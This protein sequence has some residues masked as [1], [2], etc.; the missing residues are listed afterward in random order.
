M[1]WHA[2]RPPTFDCLCV[3]RQRLDSKLQ[4][5]P[6]IRMASGTAVRRSSRTALEASVCSDEQ[7]G[8]VTGSHHLGVELLYAPGRLPAR[9]GKQIRVGVCQRGHPPVADEPSVG[10]GHPDLGPLPSG[11]VG[12]A[13]GSGSPWNSSRL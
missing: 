12:M 7:N 8:F 6:P 2:K 1:S 9:H 5:G 11:A 3:A 4:V 13:E 10:L